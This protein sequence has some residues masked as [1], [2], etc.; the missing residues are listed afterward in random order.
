MK[1]IETIWGIEYHH[2]ETVKN[3]ERQRDDFRNM[4]DLV[5]AEKEQLRKERDD[6]AN[7][8]K[9]MDALHKELGI[10]DL[11][12]ETARCR[13]IAKKVTENGNG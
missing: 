3:L 7:G 9:Y 2:V 8:F 11:T 6:L 1:M 12:K 13:E 4:L 5:L 10:V